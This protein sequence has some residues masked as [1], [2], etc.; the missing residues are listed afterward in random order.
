[1]RRVTKPVV[2]KPYVKPKKFKHKVKVTDFIPD[3][4][5]VD[6][7]QLNEEEQNL[8]FNFKE[9]RNDDER[10]DRPDLV[11]DPTCYVF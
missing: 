2:R 9:D 11:E 3:D 4:Q 6:F 1:M 7:N 5:I 8:A 10:L